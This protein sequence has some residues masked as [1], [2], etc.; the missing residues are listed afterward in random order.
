MANNDRNS[1][2]GSGGNSGG[3]NGG[4]NGGNSGGSNRG[5][6]GMDRDKQREI[7]SE[8]GRVAH[9][10]GNAHEWDSESAREAGRKGGQ[11]RSQNS[12]GSGN[13]DSLGEDNR[14][15]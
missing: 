2:G 4:N 3:N 14:G 11:S 15:M 9:E 12:S 10:R 6:A 5:F 1:G 7:A 13:R 8:G